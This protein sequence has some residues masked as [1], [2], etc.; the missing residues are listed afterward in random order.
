[1]FDWMVGI[2][3]DVDSNHDGGTIKGAVEVGLYST[4]VWLPA[5]II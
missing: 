5:S 3:D 2:K 1:M 4:Y